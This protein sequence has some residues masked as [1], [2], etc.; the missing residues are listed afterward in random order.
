M[1][2]AEAEKDTEMEEL[3]ATKYPRFRVATGG[4]EPPG[5]SDP[6]HNWL[7]D[8]EVGTTFVARHKN[9]KDVDYNLY[10]VIFKWLPEVVLLKWQLPDGKLLDYYVDPERFSKDFKNPSILGIVKPPE[11]VEDNGNKQRNRTDRLANL[12]LDASVHGEHQVL[13]GTEEPDL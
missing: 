7:A 3:R 2:V 13:Q 5:P 10:R 4:K 6:I 9:S 1:S 8:Y 11:E 12:V